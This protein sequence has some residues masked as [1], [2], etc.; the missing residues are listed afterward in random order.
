VTAPGLERDNI[1]HESLPTTQKIIPNPDIHTDIIAKAH[2]AANQSQTIIGIQLDKVQYS[3]SHQDAT[4][5]G[6]YPP[7]HNNG[8]QQ[9]THHERQ[10]CQSPLENT[11]ADHQAPSAPSLQIDPGSPQREVYPPYRYDD[12]QRSGHPESYQSPYPSNK[13]VAHRPT[14]PL[15]APSGPQKP[16]QLPDHTPVH[17]PRKTNHAATGI[18][19]GFMAIALLALG[20][21]VWY[22]CLRKRKAGWLRSRHGSQDTRRNAGKWDADAESGVV[23]DDS[24]VTKYSDSD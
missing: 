13:T 10:R 5:S 20:F 3:Q 6:I 24:L 15:P 16:I 7:Y 19:S 17:K 23:I 14:P 22:K 21:T 8:Q 1:G 9:L 4:Q 11:T 18:V 12:Q 2:M